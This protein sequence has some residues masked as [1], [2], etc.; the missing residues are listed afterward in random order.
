MRAP[1]QVRFGRTPRRLR[2][3]L[4]LNLLLLALVGLL[5]LTYPVEELS[6]RLSDFYFRLRGQQPIS[7]DVALVLIDDASLE[8][9]GRWPWPRS[10]LA[11]VVRAASAHGP[12][13]LG[14]DV[15]LSEPEDENN[16]RDLAETL[17]A[18]GNV[19]LVAKLGGS[20]EG[21]PWVEPLPLFA[22]SAARVGH[23]QAA[24]GPDSICRSVPVRELTTEGPRW[25]FALEVARVA[26]GA[27]LKDDPGGLWLGNT[28]VPLEGVAARTEVAEWQKIPPRF[29]TIDY[30]GQLLP[31]QPPPFSAIPARDLLKGM[32]GEQL[33]GKAVLIGFAGTEIGDRLPTP[34]SDRLPMPGVEIHANLVDALLAGRYLESFGA[35]VQILLLVAG[36]LL[37]TWV[38]LRWPGPKGLLTLAG[39]LLASYAGGYLLFAQAHRLIDF[40]PLLCMG[41]LAGPLAQLENLI[42]VGRGLTRSLRHLQRT[43]RT[44][45]PEMGGSLRAAL[46]LGISTPAGDLHWKVELLDQLQAELGA[47]YAFDQTLLE[48]MQEGL[49]VFAPDGRLVFRNPPWQRFCQQQNWNVAASLDEFLVALG[50]PNW[51]NLRARLSE[52]GAWLESEVHLGE[53]LWQV[54]AVPLPS[55]AHAGTGCLMVVVAN[56]TARLERDQARAQ[57]LS[58]VTHELRTPLLSIQGFAEFLLRYRKDT[59]D[60]EAATAI[61]RESRRLV[62]MINT[63]LDV[64]RLEAGSRPMLQE[65]VD[66]TGMVTQVERVMQPLAQ[67][68]GISVKAETD[69]GLPSL[70]GDPHLIA[71]VLLNLLS[72]AVKYSPGGSEVRLRVSAEESNVVFE[73]WNPGP[74]I[75]P[76]DLA[77]VFEPFYRRP[78]QEDSTLGWGLG[79]TFVKRIVE[80]HGGRVE[81]SSGASTGTC[82]RISIPSAPV[83]TCEAIL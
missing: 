59:A 48:A 11:R 37:S 56:L 53:G 45:T 46:R 15:L 71:G 19:V 72:N 79:L 28:Q 64:L 54:R 41:L 67:G 3:W 50:E 68:A 29:L 62:A 61:F 24:L 70:R 20:P 44:A 33:R 32:A 81:A 69:S 25:A 4:L 66:I 55:T 74:A 47:L 76:Q 51:R 2:D 16:D 58:F 21:R 43:L 63:Y 31:R 77:R 80:G 7:P 30:R 49:A 18:A 57:A 34:I 38:V 36:S 78:E 12:R 6:R 27:A 75:P 9:Y 52:P 13:A 35:S 1:A 39:L 83:L 23:A 73:V 42:M 65:L 22:Q 40:G 82:F 5:S 26:R 60:S 17:K 10:L 14:L 8:R